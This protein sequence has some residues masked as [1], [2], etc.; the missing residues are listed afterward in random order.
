MSITKH[1]AELLE[2]L[3]GIEVSM[4][5]IYDVLLSAIVPENASSLNLHGVL[6]KMAESIDDK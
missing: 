6:E 1:N 4:A 2:V 3:K 5:R